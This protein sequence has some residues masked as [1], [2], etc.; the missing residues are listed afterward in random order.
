VSERRFSPAAARD[1]P[2]RLP[3]NRHWLSD[4]V[5]GSA[6]GIIAGRTVTSHEAERPFPVAVAVIPGGAAIMYVRRNK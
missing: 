3:A 6:V 2:L 4:A 1:D 5:F